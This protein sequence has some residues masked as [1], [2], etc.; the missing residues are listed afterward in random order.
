MIPFIR[1]PKTIIQIKKGIT[2]K[3]GILAPQISEA[4]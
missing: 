3:H 4:L 2:K 1:S